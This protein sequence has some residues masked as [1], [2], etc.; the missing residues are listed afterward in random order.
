[1]NNLT[2]ISKAVSAARSPLP[3][4]FVLRT[5]HRVGVLQ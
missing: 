1:M 5:K 4:P 3:H 2:L